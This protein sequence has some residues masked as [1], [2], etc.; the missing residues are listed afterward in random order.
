M[1]IMSRCNFTKMCVI[2]IINEC[3]A[4]CSKNVLILDSLTV[5]IISY[6]PGFDWFEYVFVIQKNSKHDYSKEFKS[7][8]NVFFLM[9]SRQ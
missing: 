4:L 3:A 7:S 2:H 9:W 1:L 6:T 5:D 8:K